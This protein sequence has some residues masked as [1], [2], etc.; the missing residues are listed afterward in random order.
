MSQQA[1]KP[2]RDWREIAA[3]AEKETD[4]Q[5]LEELTKELVRAL[6]GRDNNS[7]QLAN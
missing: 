7:N 2:K 3:E 6:D 4:P 5:L 1:A